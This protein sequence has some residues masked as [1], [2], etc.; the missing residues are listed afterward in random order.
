MTPKLCRANS[1]KPEDYEGLNVQ[2]WVGPL[3]LNMQNRLLTSD[4]VLSIARTTYAVVPRPEQLSCANSC[5]PHCCIAHAI[6]K[7]AGVLLTVTHACMQQTIQMNKGC[8]VVEAYMF[9]R[10]ARQQLVHDM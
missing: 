6:G 8:K 7:L 2:A 4:Y 5:T 1:P 10:C 3:S 9:S